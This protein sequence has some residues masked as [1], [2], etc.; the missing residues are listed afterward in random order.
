MLWNNGSI[1]QVCVTLMV[2]VVCVQGIF[3]NW[4]LVSALFNRLLWPCRVGFHINFYSPIDSCG[5]PA[6]FTNYP[7]R[8]LPSCLWMWTQANPTRLKQVRL[9]WSEQAQ[10]LLFL[11]SSWCGQSNNKAYI[12]LHSVTPQN[13]RDLMGWCIWMAFHVI[14]HVTEY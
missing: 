14:L 1:A 8:I 4:P 10:S 13:Q 9:D 6:P 3:F 5:H 11:I 7:F 2:G 12:Q